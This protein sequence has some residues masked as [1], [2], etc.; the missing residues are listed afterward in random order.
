MFGE[1][2]LVLGRRDFL[3]CWLLPEGDFLIFHLLP[4]TVGNSIAQ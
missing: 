2:I 3:V 4:A 1:L